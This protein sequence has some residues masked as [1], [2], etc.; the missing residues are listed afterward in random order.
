[1][2]KSLTLFILGGYGTFGGRIVELL[3][4]EPRLTLIIAGRSFGKAKAFCDSR[5]SAKATL[6]PLVFDRAGDIQAQLA[7]VLPNI[8]IDASGPFQ[9]YGEGAYRIIDACLARRIHY[10]DLA[11]GSDFVAGVSAYNRAARAAGLFILSGVSSFPVLTAAVVRHLS[12]DMARVDSIRGGIAPS[13]FAGVGLNVIRAIA[14]YAGQRTKLKRDG[15]AA[16]G[17]PLTETTRYTIRPPGRLP[18]RNSL[19]SLVDVPDLR[20]LDLLWPQ[21]RSIWMGAAPVPE[22][23]HRALITLAWL[24]RWKLIPTLAPL[25]PLM[26]FTTNHFRWGEHRGGMFVEVEGAS[27]HGTPLK[28]SWHLLAEGSDG[29]LIPS[30]AVEA[31]IRKALQGQLPQAGA[32]AATRELEV[33]DYEALFADRQIFTGQRDE[34][35]LADEELYPAHIGNAFETLPA[36]VQAMHRTCSMAEGRARV[37][38]G[39]G[40]LAERV[41]KAMGFPQAGTEVPLRVSFERHGGREIWTR[42]FGNHEFS[43]EHS[44]GRGRD[45]GLVCERFGPLSFAMAVVVEDNKLRLVLRR[46]SAFGLPMPMALCPRAEAFEHGEDGCFRFDVS[47]SHPLTGLIVRYEGWLKPTQP[48]L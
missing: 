33:E 44:A 8:L 36:E 12:G 10:L 1:M 32:R 35:A 26:H 30:M 34:T 46:W 4:N 41:A 37:T 38:R 48:S 21:A 20:A 3:E 23:L 22:I 9:A 27:E 17:F 15:R 13:P 18:L 24:V 16:I 2:T 31:L 28:R 6:M 19:F 45:K 25:A 39:Q 7:G 5:T 40:F 42:R 29:P 14:T 47:I 11:D 43:S